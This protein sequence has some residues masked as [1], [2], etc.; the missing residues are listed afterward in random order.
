[1][2]GAGITHWRE[3]PTL[4]SPFSGRRFLLALVILGFSPALAPEAT[5]STYRF[6]ENG[7][8]INRSE[9]AGFLTETPTRLKIDLSG[10]WEYTIDNGPSGSVKVPSAYDFVAKVDFRRK[11]GITS[12]QID[13]YDFHLVMLGSNYNTEVSINGEFITNHA[14]G[15]TS[16]VVPIPPN[17]LQVGSENVIQVTTNNE[18]DARKTLPLRSLVW[19]WR[20]YGGIIRDIFILGTPKLAIGEVQATTE[21]FSDYSSA[22][23][24]ILASF[25]GVEPEIPIEGDR[26]RRGRSAS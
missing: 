13:S 5:S 11:I 23:V 24:G 9:D 22:K 4:S 1:M 7:S 16:F 14:G 26:E 19:G 12:S 10:T 2:A 17:V 8:P 25:E 20:N 6:M 21:F 3:V 18:L 15:Y